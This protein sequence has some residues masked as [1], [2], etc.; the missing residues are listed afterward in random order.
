[1][2]EKIIQFESGKS[3]DIYDDLFTFAEIH[4]LEYFVKNSLFKSNGSDGT[5]YAH[6]ANQ[7][8]STYSQ[9]D[10]QNMGILNMDGFKFINDKYKLFEKNIG[11]IRVNLSAPS[12][13][14]M[15]HSDHIA[16]KTLIYYVNSLWD[17]SWGGHTLFMDEK[18]ED[19]KHTCLFKTGRL[20]VFDGAIPHMIMTPSSLCPT[21]RYSFVIQ[22]MK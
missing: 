17:V 22:T 21:F 10:L 15:V 9:D 19:A 11:Q 2:K 7:I 18:L 4:H 6:L 12:E 8:Y 20:V 1:M 16:G 13:K 5:N 14:N 3:V